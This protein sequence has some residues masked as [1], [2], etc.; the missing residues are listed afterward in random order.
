MMITLEQLVKRYIK[1]TDE[2]KEL[3]DRL[4]VNETETIA[5]RNWL[6]NLQRLEDERQ[7]KEL[8]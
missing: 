2:M 5:N 1:M 6:E 3:K 8:L 7:D 4:L